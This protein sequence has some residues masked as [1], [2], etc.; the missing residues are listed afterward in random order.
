MPV[1]ISSITFVIALLSDEVGKREVNSY[2]LTL[3]TFL[4]GKCSRKEESRNIIE[5]RSDV[6]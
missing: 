6:N 1:C 4:M 2:L 5:S 3:T